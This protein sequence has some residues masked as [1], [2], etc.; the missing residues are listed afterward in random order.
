MPE[1][2]QT[3]SC[4]GSAAPTCLSAAC[5]CLRRMSGLSGLPAY[6]SAPGKF[7]A[8]DVNKV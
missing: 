3:V 2:M 1:Q 7:K 8:G 5:K 4:A 6:N